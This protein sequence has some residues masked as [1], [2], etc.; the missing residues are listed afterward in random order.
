M[1]ARKYLSRACC[2]WWAFPPSV[3][4]QT[5]KTTLRI[6]GHLRDLWHFDSLKTIPSG[7]RGEAS[8]P[9]EASISIPNKIET[10]SDRITVGDVCIPNEYQRSRVDAWMNMS[11]SIGWSSAL[12]KNYMLFIAPEYNGVFASHRHTHTHTHTHARTH[13]RSHARTHTHD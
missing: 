13:A 4:M 3:S 8:M 11:A 10:S 7:V 12:Y 2:P 6:F 1:V 5:I 9:L